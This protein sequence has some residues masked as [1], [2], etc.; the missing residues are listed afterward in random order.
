MSNSPLITQTS[1][2][3]VGVPVFFRRINWGVTL[4]NWYNASR[5]T[6]TSFNSSKFMDKLTCRQCGNVKEYTNS[7]MVWNS[8]NVC[9]IPSFPVLERVS[10][11]FKSVIW[12]TQLVT[13]WWVTAAIPHVKQKLHVTPRLG[14]PS[15][16]LPLYPSPCLNTTVAKKGGEGI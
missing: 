12:N 1:I 6:Y 7:L 9:T 14:T 2:F 13:D 10:S 3:T 8:V 11:L 16:L 4:E 15:P 5:E